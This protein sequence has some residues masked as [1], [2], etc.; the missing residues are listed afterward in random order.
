MKS[1]NVNKDTQLTYRVVKYNPL[2]SEKNKEV[3]SS[4]KLF[5]TYRGVKYAI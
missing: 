1:S 3:K 4:S 2:N 5:G